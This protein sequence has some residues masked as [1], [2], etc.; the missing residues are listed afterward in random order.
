MI[1]D[2]YNVTVDVLRMTNTSDDMGG[3]TEV[4]VILHN[5]LKCR[6]NWVRGS[7]KVMFDRDTWFRD[8]KMYCGVVD[9]LTKDRV[10]YNG[11][12]YEVV[13]VSNV[14]NMDRYMVVDLRLVE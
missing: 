9:I 11:N 3:W 12:T 4:E 13:N 8:A 1:T 10:L 5:D 2:L 6:I 7:E 14:D